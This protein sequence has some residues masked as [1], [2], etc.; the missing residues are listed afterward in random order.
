[1]PNG[2]S[3]WIGANEQRVNFVGSPAAI[4]ADIQWQDVVTKNIGVD[5]GS[6]KKQAQCYF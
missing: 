6:I 1:M 2:Q 3:T 5:I 4:D